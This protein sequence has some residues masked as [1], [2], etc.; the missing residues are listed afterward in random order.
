MQKK[1]GCFKRTYIYYV[2]FVNDLKKKYLNYAYWIKKSKAF[3]FLSLWDEV[4]KIQP[5]NYSELKAKQ[6]KCN[7]R[8]NSAF[9]NPLIN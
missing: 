9:K 4:G 3:L 5:K 6:M 2:K 8:S 7:L 1:K